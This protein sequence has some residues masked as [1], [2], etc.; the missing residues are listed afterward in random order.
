MSFVQLI[1]SGLIAIITLV[2]SNAI[3]AQ[4]KPG[5]VY[6]LDCYNK[7]GTTTFINVAG[8]LFDDFTGSFADPVSIKKQEEAGQQIVDHFR[9]NSKL[10]NRS[11]PTQKLRTILDRLVRNIRDPKGFRYEIFYMDTSIL[12]AFTAGGKIFVTRKM[13]E[14]CANDDELACI[15][16][17][18]IAHNEL[19]HLE[20]TLQKQNLFT[21]MMGESMGSIAYTISNFMV[22]SFNQKDE[23]YSDMRGMDIA[24]AAGYNICSNKNLWERMEKENGGGDDILT[25]FM[26]SHPYS[27]TRAKCVS[28]HVW[29]NYKYR[30][31]N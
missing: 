22:T 20:K 18:E 14:F 3:S 19:G 28:D 23:A 26:S 24:K 9:K 25:T 16:G 31:P 29:R 17:H 6:D 4:E 13:M 15:I 30:C 8:E 2:I 12:N 11:V 5:I 7:D 1:K 27:G 10:N 21:D